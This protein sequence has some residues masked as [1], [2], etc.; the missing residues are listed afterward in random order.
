MIVRTK[1]VVMRGAKGFDRTR[2]GEIGRTLVFVVL[3]SLVGCDPG[4]TVRQINSFVESENAAVVPTPKI[5]VNVKT[6]HQMIG[7]RWYGPQVTATNPSD[8]P[9]TITSVELI[10]SSQTLKNEDIAAKDYPATLPA[11]ST[12]P[13]GIHF[14]FSDGVDVDKAFKNPG[15]LRIHYSSQQG[16][17]IVRVTVIRGPLNAK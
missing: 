17:G 5:S 2:G 12:V 16:A 9:V 7:E 11:R 1:G 3:M 13:L 15:E 8:I 10:A 14:R 6:T 4:M